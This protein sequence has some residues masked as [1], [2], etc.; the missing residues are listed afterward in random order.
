MSAAALD[1]RR[2]WD[3]MGAID[4]AALVEIERRLGAAM[5]ATLGLDLSGLVLDMTSFAIYIDSANDRADIAQRGHAKQ[6]RADLRIVDLGLVVTTDGGVPLCSH[7][8]AGSRPDVSQLAETV[9][10]L[11]E[12]WGALAES[13]DDLTLVYDAGQDSEPD[14]A[15][16]EAGPLHLVGSVPPSDHPELLAVSARRYRPVDTTRHPGLTAFETR[17]KAL[18]AERRLIVTHSP[19]LH[20]KQ[21]QGLAQTTAKAGRLLAE[22]AGRLAGGRSRKDRAGVEA[23]IAKR[24]SGPA[25]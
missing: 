10:E 9:T 18:D 1:H 22:L 8:Y 4:D 16:I 6:R 15:H 3:A 17:G 21:V 5:V 7:A 2:F 14:Q 24:S 20:D 11:V 12:R 13:T 23:E 19:S 25:G